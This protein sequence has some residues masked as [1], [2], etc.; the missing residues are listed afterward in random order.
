MDERDT[1]GNLETTSLSEDELTRIRKLKKKSGPRRISLLITY[2]DGVRVVPLTEGQSTVLGRSPPADVS[3]RD[4][5]LSRQHA[6]IEL[7]EGEVWVEDLQSTN[8]TWLNGARI[9]RVKVEPADDL[10]F[11]TVPATVYVQ[12]SDA[13]RRLGLD[14]HD[15][16]VAELEAEVERARIFERSVALLMLRCTRRNEGNLG[17]WFPA[18]KKQLRAFDKMALYSTDTVEI[19]LPE[20]TEQEACESAGK[21]QSAEK[22]LICGLGVLPPHASSADELIEVARN[23]LQR[24]DETKTLCVA[25]P[26]KP[27]KQADK[28][29]SEGELI[30][31]SQAMKKLRATVGKLASSVIPVLIAGETGSG[32]EVIA[33]AIHAG[34]GRAGKPMRC[35][36]CG[37]IPPN[38]VESTLF[39]HEKGAFTGANQKTEG[40][41]ESA[42]GGTVLL[43]EIGELP[44]PAQAALLRVLET[45]R[46]TRIGSSREIE[47]DVR[48]LAAT[49][50]NLEELVSRGEFR[51]D[52][53]YRLNAMSLT[54]PPLRERPEEIA[55]LAMH[56]LRQANETNGCDV[57]SIDDAAVALL[58][59]Y[60]WPGNV[61]ELRN[62][63][64]RAVVIA[65][66]DAI[67]VE[68]LPEKIRALEDGGDR[69]S[70][71][72][73][74]EPVAEP[75]DLEVNLKAEM[76]QH[77]ASLILKALEACDFD[78][79]EAA[80]TLGIPLR[81]LA[82]KMQTHGIKSKYGVR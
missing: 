79:K 20:A 10:T 24:A 75:E 42:D 15:R 54:V 56:F 49:N 63:I 14:G 3:L 38:L 22:G 47:V 81:T 36:N 2:R 34:S 6:C 30:V 11:G 62:A 8:G 65:Q 33:R 80:R 41:F 12:A 58:E 68:D 23:A 55:P 74:T 57:K 69:R 82:H 73:S 27:W 28:T 35:V 67:G 77:E 5:S 61:R 72:E 32:K 71:E 50:K 43:D 4:A 48:I 59:S 17:K 76:N 64:E 18:V 78:R 16:F 7:L 19:I 46:F 45:K 70:S 9:E 21:I 52:L 25:G 40:I 51:E 13:E 44:P 60:F 37:G 26:A 53:L 31:E 66:A 29:E 1:N 39:G